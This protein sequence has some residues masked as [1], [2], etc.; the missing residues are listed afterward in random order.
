MKIDDPQMGEGGGVHTKSNNGASSIPQVGTRKIY[1]CQFFGLSIGSAQF[2]PRS[3]HAYL[4]VLNS[5]NLAVA[6]NISTG[7]KILLPTNESESGEIL[8]DRRTSK[9]SLLKK[10][11]ELNTKNSEF[12]TITATYD[13][14]GRYIFTGNSEGGIKIIDAYLYQIVHSISCGSFGSIKSITFNRSGDSFL[15]NC[16]DRNIRLFR[17]V[18][19]QETGIQPARVDPTKAIANSAPS[20]APAEKKELGVE[21][22]NGVGKSAKMPCSVFSKGEFILEKK[23]QDLVNRI[24]WKKCCFSTDGDYVVAGSSQ[25]ASHN[26]YLWERNIGNLTKILEGPKEGLLDIVWHPVRPIIASISAHGIIFLWTTNFNENWSA[27]APDFKELEENVEYIER[28]DEFDAN[29]DIADEEKRIEKERIDA[30]LIDITTVERIAAFEDGEE[31]NNSPG[32]DEEEFETPEI[33]EARKKIKFDDY[34]SKANN[35]ENSNPGVF[36]LSFPIDP[37][38]SL[39]SSVQYSYSTKNEKRSPFESKE[40]EE[41]LKGI[42]NGEGDIPSGS[43]LEP[44]LHE[45]IAHS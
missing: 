42:N 28:E 34:G 37:D 6:V 45:T 20:L 40:E 17:F 25:R 26:I 11:E 19:K 7:E 8:E 22:S 33:S 21:K 4:V 2:H 35:K 24:H 18:K 15:V 5:L 29:D 43:A 41:K 13:K 3:K 36:T 30:E 12:N 1:S 10:R 23:F 39:T 31:E 9:E 44:N 14:R 38:Y 27:F 16:A 32:K